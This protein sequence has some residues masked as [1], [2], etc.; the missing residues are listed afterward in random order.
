VDGYYHIRIA[1]SIK[2]EGVKFSFPWAQFSTFRRYYADKELLFH[3]LITPFTF[4]NLNII[5]QG[6]MAVV[7]FIILFNIIF[8]YIAKKYIL[9]IFVPLIL[10]SLTLSC[11]FFFYI[12][13]L[14]PMTLVNILLLLLMYALIEE[15][16]IIVFLVSIIYPLSH[17]SFLIIIP[18]CIFAE[19]IRFTYKRKFLWRNVVYPLVGLNIGILIHPHYPNNLV[20]LHL[21]GILVPFYTM[22]EKVR[23]DFGS[24][25][26]PLN[27]RVV[28]FDFF[29]VI[30]ML[31]LIMFLMLIKRYK[32]TFITGICFAFFV[33]FLMLGFFSL[34][35]WYHVH[36]FG[37][38]F[39]FSFFS[40]CF[41]TNSRKFRITMLIIIGCIM[42]INSLLVNLKSKCLIKDMDNYIKLNMHY[43]YMGFFAK[44]HIP[45]GKT[46]YHALWSDSPYF[47]CLNPKNRYLIVLDPIYMFYYDKK[48][49][50]CYTG[51]R[52]GKFKE[53]YKVIYELFGA[54]Y[55]Y[56]PSDAKLY[57]QVIKD[58]KHF[59][60][61]VKDGWGLIFKINYKKTP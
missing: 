43:E 42:L 25:F 44:H 15:K 10:L 53:P 8:F 1:N 55:G 3:L 41:S 31:G 19:I 12:N 50:K 4:L 56:V 26:N 6:K 11:I 52:D 14:R 47:M 57:R 17:I 54:E 30:A 18:L 29:V 59:K 39:V 27:T 38:L 48:L 33:M 13:Y 20:S 34:R 60:I 61:L 58:K 24:E 51:L 46:F 2:N 45:P 9:K 21:N 35:Y 40:D 28:L 16:W 37:L 5:L 49:Y 23:L 22:F 7:F 32:T 36:I